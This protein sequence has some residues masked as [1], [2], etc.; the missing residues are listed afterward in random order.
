MENDIN[1]R[2]WFDAYRPTDPSLISLKKDYDG[3]MKN[4]PKDGDLTEDSLSLHESRRAVLRSTVN[5]LE[6]KLA[7]PM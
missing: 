6:S 7:L 1:N 3:V 2:I 5:V 4:L